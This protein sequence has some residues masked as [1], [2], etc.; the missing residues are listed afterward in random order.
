M[1]QVYVIDR[2]TRRDI[3]AEVTFAAVNGEWH[4]FNRYNVDI[5]YRV[6]FASEAELDG[7][8]L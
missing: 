8:K 4:V 5:T 7:V 1:A 6:V 2:L 3:T